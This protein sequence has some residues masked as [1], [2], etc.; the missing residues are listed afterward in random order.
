MIRVRVELRSCRSWLPWNLGS[1]H[2]ARHVANKPSKVLQIL[3][4]HKKTLKYKNPHREEKYK[5]KLLKT[6]LTSFQSGGTETHRLRLPPL[7]FPN[8]VQLV[9][10]QVVDL[11]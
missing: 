7:G 3:T 2:S 11:P 5:I 4:K 10:W 1:H 6:K 8:S 9:A